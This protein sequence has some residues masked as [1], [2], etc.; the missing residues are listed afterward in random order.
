LNKTDEAIETYEKENGVNQWNYDSWDREKLLTIY[1]NYVKSDWL[2][3]F[4]KVTGKIYRVNNEYFLTHK[5]SSSRP[6]R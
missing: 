6:I 2:C 1:K 4:F 5:K 3:I